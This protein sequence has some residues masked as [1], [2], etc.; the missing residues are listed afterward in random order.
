ML[1][2]SSFRLRLQLTTLA[3]LHLNS[4]TW[5][6]TI[7]WPSSIISLELEI[8][9]IL[10]F[11]EKLYV[12][13]HTVSVFVLL[14][15]PTSF[16]ARM[17]FCVPEFG[18]QSTKTQEKQKLAVLMQ[19]IEIFQEYILSQ[20]L[21]FFGYFSISSHYLLYFCQFSFKNYCVCRINCPRFSRHHYWKFHFDLSLE[22]MRTGQFN[23]LLH[24]KQ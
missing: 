7:V 18:S 22:F 2:F 11:H 21:P 15:S 13:F 1:G 20:Y 10:C 24:S 14:L 4:M 19:T 17:R 3:L 8:L 12:K 16:S 23:M 6:R 5:T 9:R